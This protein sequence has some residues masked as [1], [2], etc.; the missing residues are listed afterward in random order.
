M[1]LNSLPPSCSQ[2]G[3]SAVSPQA[4]LRNVFSCLPPGCSHQHI[5]SRLLSGMSFNCLPPGCSQECLST[6]SLQVVLS[7]TFQL[8]P[9]RLFSAL[10]PS[11][12]F[13]GTVPLQAVFRNIF[14]RPPGYWEECWPF[15]LIALIRVNLVKSVLTEATVNPECWLP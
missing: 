15:Q 13:S 7:N 5:P 11:R 3:L 4:V 6:V 12:L 14:Q 9:S 10:S 1:S 8:S 2:E